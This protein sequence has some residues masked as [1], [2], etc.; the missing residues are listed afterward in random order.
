VRGAWG[1]LSVAH[2]TALELPPVGLVRAAARAG[3][4]AVGLRTRAATPE[5]PAYLTQPGGRLHAALRA[6]LRAEG[7]RVSEVELVQLTQGFDP[8]EI[9]PMLESGADLGAV[10]VNVTGDD[11]DPG[12]LAESLARVAELAGDL[13]M[14][15][16]LEFMRWRQVAT[17]R[18]A[19][20]LVRASAAANA[21]VLVDA[22]HLDRSGG[23]PAEVSAEVVHAVQLSDAPLE[24]PASEA[25]VIREAREGRLPP[26]AGALPLRDLL[27]RLGPGVAFSVEVPQAGRPPEERL[28]AAFRGA[29][30][31]MDEAFAPRGAAT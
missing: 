22:L 21:G 10:A 16:D 30:G 11:P 25:E 1:D 18:D 28:A 17:Y 24:R 5:G 27:R 3:F 13:G 29:A 31:V 26:G 15:V 6:A 14:R 7:V 2:L 12:R 4:R 9:R 19:V 20:A 8:Q 23:T